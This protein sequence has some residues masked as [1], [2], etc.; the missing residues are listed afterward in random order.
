MQDLKI[1]LIIPWVDGNDPEWKKLKA[2][3]LNVNQESIPFFREWNILRYV[4]RSIEKNIPWVNCVHFVTEGHLPKWLNT[5]HPKLNIVK[6][7]D[8]IPYEYL[9]TFS[10]IPITL[11][12]H[13]IP[14]LSENFIWSNDDCFFMKELE[15]NVFFNN[16]LPCDFLY[17]KP[18]TEAY[19]G[20]FSHLIL[21][22]INLINQEF[23]VKQCY[24]QHRDKWESDAY[25]KIA[26]SYNKELVRSLNKFPGFVDSHMPL[27]FNKSSF[28]T[29]W[30]KYFTAM[31]S[32]CK[33]KFRSPSDL[34][35]WYIRYRRLCMGEFSPAFLDGCRYCDIWDNEEILKDTVLSKTTSMLCINDSS[36]EG[37]FNLRK[38]YI[39]NLLERVFPEQSSF[40]IYTDEKTRNYT[41]KKDSEACNKISFPEIIK[42]EESLNTTINFLRDNRR[43]YSDK[44]YII[45]TTNASFGRTL[46]K[47]FDFDLCECV[48][49]CKKE[50]FVDYMLEHSNTCVIFA[51]HRELYSELAEKHGV[52]IVY[53]S[54]E[55]L[56]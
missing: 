22:Q 24:E 2:E 10:S 48:E 53:F 36:G 9:P 32:S 55:G 40:E 26:V 5:S 35:D 50:N 56:L 27:P 41:I 3:Y 43:K 37:D 38:E 42:D 18:F 30:A 21:T 20:S 11:N 8:F 4:F 39:H 34:T 25:S 29:V 28:A 19:N 13:R 23:D 49:L 12:I 54:D 51:Q 31:D 46:Q 16:G 33:N 7:T 6:H 1:D 47:L 52:D 15:P 45:K 17:L 44:T 14:G